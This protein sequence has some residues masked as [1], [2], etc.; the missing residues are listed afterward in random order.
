KFL[1]IGHSTRGYSAEP[2]EGQDKQG[3]ESKKRFLFRYL[4]FPRSARRER[5]KQ[6]KGREPHVLD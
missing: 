6:L 5:E 3:W 2:I 4:I 1:K